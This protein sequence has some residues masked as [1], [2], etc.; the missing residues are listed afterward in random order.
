[1]ACKGF[2]TRLIKIDKELTKLIKKIYTNERTV[3]ENNFLQIFSKKGKQL[4][5]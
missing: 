2:Y 4:F 5:V 3:I 1:M